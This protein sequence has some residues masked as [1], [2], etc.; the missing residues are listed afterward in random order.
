MDEYFP[1]FFRI[2]IANHLSKHSQD[3]TFWFSLLNT[4]T[5]NS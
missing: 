2:S 1:D 3:W 5:Y 4:G